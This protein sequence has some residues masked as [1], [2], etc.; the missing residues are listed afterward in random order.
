MARKSMLPNNVGKGGH[1]ESRPVW[2][3]VQ[4]INHQNKFAPT[5][6]FTRFGRIPVSAAKPKAASSTSAAKPGHPHQALKNKGIVDNWCSRH[7]TGNKAY[8]AD[9]QEINDGGFVA[10]GSSRGKITGKGIVD[11]WCSRHTTENKAY[12]ADYQEINDG[13]F[14]AFGSSRGKIT[15]KVLLRIPRQSNMY[16]IDLQNVVPSG[17]LTCLFAKA[18]IDESN[19]WHMRLGHVNF[20]T[21]NKLVK[22]NLVRGLPSMI[23][24]NDHTCVACHKGK[25]HKATCKAKLVSSISQPLQMLHMDL[26]GLTFVMSINHKKYCLVVT[27]DFS[28]FSWVFFLAYKDET[29]KVLKPFINAIENQINKKVKVIRSDNGTKFKNRDLD[30]FCGMKGIKREYRTVRTSQQNRVAERKNMTLIEA[31]RTMLADSFLP[32]T[33]WAEQLPRL[34]FMRPFG[35]HVTILNTLDPLG[36]FKGKADEGFL[37]RYS[38]TSK[39]FRVFDTKTKKIE[40]NLHG[41]KLTKMQVYKILMA[42]QSSISSTY[43]SSDDKA[44]DDKPK[45]DT[46]S[47]TVVELINKEDQAYRDELD[48]LMRQ[49]K[50]RLVMQRIPLERS[51]N[52]DAWIKEALLKLATLTILILLVIQLMLSDTAELRSNGIFTSAYDDDL[53]TFTSIVQSVGAE[54]DFNNME[55]S[56]VLSPIPTHKVHRNKKDKRGIIVRNKA[57]LVAQGHIQEERI[58]YGEVF[59]LVAR[60]E[61]IR[62]FLAFASFM[63]F[64]VY[65]MDVKSAFL[66][67]TIEEEVW[68][69]EEGIFISQ[70]KYVVEILKKFDF[71]SVRTTSTPI[72]TQK[73][74]VKDKEDKDVDVTPKLSHLHAVKQI[75]RYLKGQPKLGIW[76]LRDSPFD[77]EAY[78]DSD[79]ARAKLDRKSTKGVAPQHNMV[80]Y[81][82]KTEGNAEFHQIVDFLTSSF[83]HHALTVS[84][85]IYAS[86]IKQ[87][88][89]TTNSQ[90]IND[91]KQIYATVDGK[92]VVITES[93]V[94]RDLLFTD[95][96]GITLEPLNDVYVTPTLTKKVYSNMIRKSEKFSGTVTPLFASMLAQ[97]AVAK[98]EGG[99]DSLV[100]ATSTASLDAQQDSSNIAKTQSKA[101]LNEP[102]P[103][104]EG[105][106]SG[107]GCQ[108]FMEGF[109]PFR[110]GTSR[111]HSLGRR[112]VSKQ[113]KKNLKSQQK[114]QDIDDL[115]D[116]EVTVKDNEVSTA[117]PKTHPTT[118]LFD[119]EDVTIADTLVK[120]KS[121]KAKKKGVTFKE[122]DDSAR[123][124]RSITTLQP[125]PTIDPKD[126]G[127]GI[128]QEPKPV[129]KTKKKDQDQIER[130]AEVALKIQADLD[131]EVMTERERQEEA[132]KAALAGLY[133]E[134][135]AQIDVDHELAARL[136][137][138]EQEMYTIEERSK[139][140]AEFFE[141]RKKQLAKE[142]AEA[143]M[144]KPPTKTQSFEEIQKLYTKEHKWVDTFVPIG[145]EEDK[146]RVGS[147]KKRAAGTS[148]KQKSLKKQKVNDQESVDSDVNVYKLTRLDG[149][150][151]YFS[152]FFRML[153]VLDRQDVLDLH[154]IVMERFSAND[155]EGYDLILWGDLKTLMESS[156]D[157]E[158]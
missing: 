138:E 10:F 106:G 49:E 112:N 63:G 67:G 31:A 37:V 44:E 108:E 154:K 60:I 64:I 69:S 32:I 57:R 102:N 96:N 156:E 105:S 115:V 73:P 34:E 151:R 82:E 3:N 148:S 99:G 153:E 142:M 88:W 70:D 133:D 80:A 36:K 93:L 152:T 78:S 72:E 109:H 41:I 77:L 101:T 89:N 55:F 117:K 56:T 5:A 81:L 66:Y 132:S 50:K 137:H 79:Y 158:I 125:L 145:S 128:L 127:K 9:Y 16:Y 26:F 129:K 8:L 144:S 114:F 53:D 23:F 48:K 51:L 42:M 131:E 107:P 24:E 141:R 65:Q 1:R 62:I 126:K 4:R 150:Y 38:V 140:L 104:R 71:S 19:L 123:P 146:K 17:D 90:T 87:F 39:A 143:I 157:D 27:D 35:C 6:V 21:M 110:A 33:F 113:G 103:Q 95:D 46:D 22:E 100:R 76:Y 134:V 86:N 29:S 83:I 30:E 122:T 11:N 28:R 135:Q 7:M 121:Q 59:A 85:T 119:D 92:T 91:E 111:R 52:K 61:A 45:D 98:G 74:L 120:M 14:V 130:N 97:S 68:H 47:K 12:L 20:K 43:K 18:S 13:G 118:T 84:P 139:L 25:Q 15:G 75:F 54:A 136:T 94:R 58:N 124:I 155:P 40:E 149:S 116:E 2:N 147:K